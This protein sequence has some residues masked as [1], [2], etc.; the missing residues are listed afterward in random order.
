MSALAHQSQ[1]AAALER[2]EQLQAEV[3]VLRPMCIENARLHQDLD[4]ANSELEV[5]TTIATCNHK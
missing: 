5:F 1:L 2:E 3:Q 4:A